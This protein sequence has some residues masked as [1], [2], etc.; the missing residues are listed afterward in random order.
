MVI[1]FMASRS[2]RAFA[3]GVLVTGLI[4]PTVACEKVP[5]FAPSGSSIKLTAAATALPL[6]GSTD[7][8]AQ[9]IRAS[10]TPPHSGTRLTFTTNLGR[11]E[12]AEADTDVGGR[13]VVKFVAS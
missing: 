3:L 6:N 10:G 1:V 2:R 13:V 9:V 4:L 5:L 12:P 8:L 11:I 7:I